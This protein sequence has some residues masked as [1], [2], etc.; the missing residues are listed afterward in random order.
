MVVLV[1]VVVVVGVLV[2]EEFCLGQG[3]T[4]VVC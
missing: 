3:N 4:V 2:V 1:V